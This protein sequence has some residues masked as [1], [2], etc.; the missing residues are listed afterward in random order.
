MIEKNISLV[1]PFYIEINTL[2]I[3]GLKY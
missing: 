2:E 3:L 1:D